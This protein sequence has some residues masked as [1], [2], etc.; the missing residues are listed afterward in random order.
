VTSAICNL[1]CRGQSPLCPQVS[2]QWPPFPI[3]AESLRNF[4]KASRS[5]HRVARM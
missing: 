4:P 2:R 1:A 5:P 3:L